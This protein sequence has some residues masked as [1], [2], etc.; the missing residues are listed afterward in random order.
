M[1]R[2]TTIPLFLEF[3][4]PNRA[5]VRIGGLSRAVERQL[6]RSNDLVVY[7]LGSR[8]AASR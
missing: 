7:S 1:R 8:H 6:S 5:S 2:K 4:N 3:N